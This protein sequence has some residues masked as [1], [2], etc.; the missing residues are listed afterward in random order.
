MRSDTLPGHLWPDYSI[1]GLARDE[2][3][4]TTLSIYQQILCR[5]KSPGGRPNCAMG[6]PADESP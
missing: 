5:G 4:C 2:F 6:H 1:C 3:D